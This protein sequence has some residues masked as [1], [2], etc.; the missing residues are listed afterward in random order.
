[1]PRI[2]VTTPIESRFWSKVNRSGGPDACWP[3]MGTRILSGYGQ[4]W[5]NGKHR[6]ATHIALR[7]AGR[8]LAP[9]EQACHQCDNP[10]CVNPAHLFAGSRSDNVQD[11]VAK[12]RMNL[13]GRTPA[14][15]RRMSEVVTATWASYTPEERR[16]RADLHRKR[17]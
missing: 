17:A 8:P 1:M 14:W 10:P 6:P 15:R 9:G 12:G 5:E 11:M 4:I 16:A 13:A 3:W 2:Y 7:L